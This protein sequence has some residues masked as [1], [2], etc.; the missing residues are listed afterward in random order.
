[1][2]AGTSYRRPSRASLP[3]LLRVTVTW[4]GTMPESMM[5][6]NDLKTTEPAEQFE[7]WGG[8]IGWGSR[9]RLW[10]AQLKTRS[11][12]TPDPV[13]AFYTGLLMC[14]FAAT[15]HVA[16]HRRRSDLRFA[17]GRRPL[18]QTAT[19]HRMPHRFRCCSRSAGFLLSAIPLMVL[20]LR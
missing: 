7:L 8:L 1:M 3:S 19:G 20:L 9:L 16:H 12:N 18:D 17:L 2:D 5:M 14:V 6:S 13:S 11:I 4:I 10:S 15:I